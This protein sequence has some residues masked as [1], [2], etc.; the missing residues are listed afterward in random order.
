MKVVVYG[1]KSCVWC[2]KTRK[3]LKKYN[4]KFKDI[5]IEKSKSAEKKMIKISGQEGFPVINVNG[6]II[7]GYDEPKLRSVLNI[8]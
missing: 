1:T 5:D 4:I 2:G 7:L 6:K 8:K 3:F